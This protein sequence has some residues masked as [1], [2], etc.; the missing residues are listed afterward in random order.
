LIENAWSAK[1][2]EMP[3]Y[4]SEQIRRSLD[5]LYRADSGRILAT[6]IRLLGD[7][8]L[9]EDAMHEAFAAALDLWHKPAFLKI[10]G[11]G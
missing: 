10:R 3:E 11:L 7:F 8:N 9:A 2:F 5:I 1:F 6:L 4:A